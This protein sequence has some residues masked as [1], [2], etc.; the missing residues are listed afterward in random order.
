[1]DQAIKKISTYSELQEEKKKLKEEIHYSKEQ[2][3]RSLND[4]GSIAKNM[5]LKGVVLPAGIAGLAVAGVKAVQAIRND[6][7]AES[8][9]I[10]AYATYDGTQQPGIWQSIKNNL[11]SNSKWY[12]RMLPVAVDL[13]RNYIANR[14]AQRDS[15]QN[16][17]LEDAQ[18]YPTESKQALPVGSR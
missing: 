15:Y 3:L 4:T 17:D 14:K 8:Q 18:L 13:I 10:D 6:H 7:H 1:M 11:K 16:Q 5:V 12:L 9:T 2:L